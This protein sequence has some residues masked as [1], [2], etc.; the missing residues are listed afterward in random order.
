MQRVLGFLAIY[1]G[2]KNKRA[3]VR[4]TKKTEGG[5]SI[6]LCSNTRMK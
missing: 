6:D 1:S 3:I 5:I 4:K 2:L